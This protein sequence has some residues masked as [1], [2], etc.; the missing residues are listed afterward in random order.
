MQPTRSAPLLPPAGIFHA[1]VTGP[2]RRHCREPEV[3][4]FFLQRC[5]PLQ[6]QVATIAVARLRRCAMALKLVAIAESLLL[7]P[8]WQSRMQVCGWR[9]LCHRLDSLQ[10]LHGYGRAVAQARRAKW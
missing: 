5:Q 9:R 10:W 1:G 3:S 6:R 2:V 8:C 4:V 7:E